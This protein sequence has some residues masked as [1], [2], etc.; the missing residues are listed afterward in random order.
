M[1][2]AGKSNRWLKPTLVGLMAAIVLVLALFASHEKLHAA[3]HQDP[4]AP[5]PAHCAVCAVAQGQVDVP[6]AEV[7]GLVARLS[8]SWTVPASEPLLP[9]D[10]DFSVASSRGPPG[11]VSSL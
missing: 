2:L 3:V 5:H 1:Q 6:S 7:S 10:A 11:S 9:K 4:A 8:F